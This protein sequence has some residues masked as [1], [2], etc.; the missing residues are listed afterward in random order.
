M[1]SLP[2]EWADQW[3][4]NVVSALSPAWTSVAP[5]R[6][7]RVSGNLFSG[8]EFGA[9]HT[10]LEALQKLFLDE[11][12]LQ[13]QAQA[14]SAIVAKNDSEKARMNI[15]RRVERMKRLLVLQYA[16][17][18]AQVVFREPSSWSSTIWIS[19]GEADNRA[20]EQTIVAQNSPV[21]ANQ[22]LIGVVEY[23]GET[24]SRVRLISDAGLA[25]AVRAMRGGLQNRELSQHVQNLLT[26]VQVR[27]DL[28]TSQEEHARFVDMLSAFESR[29]NDWKEEELAKGE[30]CG[31]SAPLFRAHKAVLKGTGFN[32]DFADEA[33]PARDLQSG[34]PLGKHDAPQIA[35]IQPGDLLATSGFDGVF[36]AGIPVAVATSIAPLKEGSFSY[37]LEA[38][39]AAGD[40]MDLQTVFVMPPLG[41][42]RDCCSPGSN[43]PQ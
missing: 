6:L 36:P 5:R 13:A 14:L 37:E 26:H 24:Q 9:L 35:L 28:F 1:V 22:A 18:P 42:A 10:Q 43:L 31:C 19:V 34:R 33:G 17:I 4:C 20:M 12:R 39:P 38:R 30:I 32:Y 23:V 3:R 41:L 16:S 27:Q 8:A 21:L 2:Q 11:Q 29:L 40:L 7:G 25:C 15:C